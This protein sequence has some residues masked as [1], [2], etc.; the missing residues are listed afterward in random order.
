MTTEEIFIKI[1]IPA[2]AAVVGGGG[3]AAYFS[4]RLNKPKTDAETQKVAAD[5][6][7]TFADGWRSYAAKLERRVT[8][9]E[10]RNELADKRY[11]DMIKEKDEQIAGLKER[12][13]VLE[14]QIP[15]SVK[16]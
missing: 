12:I 9:L 13:V 14:K 6:I 1:V 4:Y 3:V 11:E 8:D 7:V 5:V 15:E 16:A 10:K 2:V